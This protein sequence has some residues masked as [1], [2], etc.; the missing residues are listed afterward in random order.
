MSWPAAS[1]PPRARLRGLDPLLHYRITPI[2]I[3]DPPHRFTPPRWWDN[4][5][6]I[7]ASSLT[8]LGLQLPNLPPE[9]TILIHLQ[10][11]VTDR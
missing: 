2:T 9:H 4:P 10:A 1:T 8:N 6:S 5:T 11:A 7:P 3:G